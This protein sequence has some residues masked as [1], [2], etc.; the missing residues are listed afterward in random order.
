MESLGAAFLGGP[1]LF[2]ELAA[3]ADLTLHNAVEFVRVC[4]F[5]LRIDLRPMDDEV[6][7]APES[8]KTPFQQVCDYLAHTVADMSED[9]REELA[10]QVIMHY[11]GALRETGFVIKNRG[12]M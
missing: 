7:W 2:N 8:F 1:E 3:G 9:A 5:R 11:M 12:D 6:Q 10:R 4:G